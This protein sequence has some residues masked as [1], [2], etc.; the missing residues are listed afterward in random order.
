[1]ASDLAVAGFRW[2]KRWGA[3][4]PAYRAGRRVLA[5]LSGRAAASVE[6]RHC[7]PETIVNRRLVG[8][9]AHSHEVLLRFLH[10]DKIAA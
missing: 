10:S 8:L 7:G 5:F 1:M 9:S 3:M 6:W 2:T 4:L